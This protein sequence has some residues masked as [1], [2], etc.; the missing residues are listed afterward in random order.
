MPLVKNASARPMLHEAVVLDLG[1]LGAQ[2]ARLRSD[3]QAKAAAIIEDAKAHA[4]RLVES[5]QGQGYEQGHAQGLEEG[6]QAGRQEGYAA[7]HNERLEQI[8]QTT[9]AWRDVAGQWETQL[10]A[11]EQ[12]ARGACVEFAL[13]LAETLLHRV[14]EVDDRVVVDQVANALQYLLKPTA[15]R[16]HIHPDDRPALEENLPEL[17]NEFRNLTHAELVDDDTVGRGGCLLTYGQGQI[18]AT[19]ETQ[20]RR[21]VEQI[22]PESPDTPTPNPQTHNPQRP[23]PDA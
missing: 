15:A 14:I 2:A 10:T 20:F 3:A 5:A 1:D 11:M 19:L 7:A 16:I 23:T 17:V 8:D 21:I 4:S 12:E 18:D 22:L 9:T 13:R 6:R